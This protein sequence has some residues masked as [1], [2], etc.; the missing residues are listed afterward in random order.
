MTESLPSGVLKVAEECARLAEEFA[1]VY[2]LARNVNAPICI[3]ARSGLHAAI[4][5]LAA[6]ASPPPQ[7]T[8]ALSDERMHQLLVTQPVPRSIEGMIRGEPDAED[9]G[10]PSEFATRA[11]NYARWVATQ[12][13]K[14]ATPLTEHELRDIWT[15]CDR[16]NSNALHWWGEENLILAFARAIEAAHGIAA[17]S[18]VEPEEKHG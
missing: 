2:I 11:E 12:S 9:F 4:D 15:T 10:I 18:Q 14:V 16:P 1:E 6:L 3:A 7:A 8:G 5:R 17:A 13:L